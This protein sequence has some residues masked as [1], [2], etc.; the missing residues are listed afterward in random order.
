MSSVSGMLNPA[1]CYHQYWSN[2][3]IILTHRR[4]GSTFE[5]CHVPRFTMRDVQ[6]I[7][8]QYLQGYSQMLALIFV[9]KVVSL[10]YTKIFSLL[11]TSG[12]QSGGL[13]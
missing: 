9:E 11:V 12:L 1:F 13:F 4:V 7:L 8:Q 2:R 10:I 6:P 5:T 3:L